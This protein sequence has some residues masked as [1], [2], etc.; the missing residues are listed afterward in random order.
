MTEAT[1]TV[2]YTAVRKA[3][4]AYCCGESDCE[5]DCLGAALIIVA[6]YMEH[7]AGKGA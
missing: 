7:M 5:Q 3:A 6:S 1:V 4:A 2:N